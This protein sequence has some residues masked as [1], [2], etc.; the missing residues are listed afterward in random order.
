MKHYKKTL[1][2]ILN[3]VHL[4]FQ[5]QKKR[6]IKKKILNILV[7]ILMR[8]KKR[9]KKKKKAKKKVRALIRKINI[10]KLIILKKTNIKNNKK[11][12]C[13]I[14]TNSKNKRKMEHH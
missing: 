14:I 1:I 2:K 9:A 7:I 13:K 3:K 8:T 11:N 5:A 10:L 12:I 6:E 4:A